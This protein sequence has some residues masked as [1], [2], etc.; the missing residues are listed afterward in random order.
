MSARGKNLLMADADA[1]TRFSDIEKVEQR[2]ADINTNDVTH[3]SS[4]CHSFHYD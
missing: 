1:A 4:A 3:F 2:L